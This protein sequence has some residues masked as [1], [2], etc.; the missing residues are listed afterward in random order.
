MS[1]QTVGSSVQFSSSSC[2]T[3][4]SSRDEIPFPLKVIIGTTDERV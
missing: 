4:I 2:T 1:I 3:V